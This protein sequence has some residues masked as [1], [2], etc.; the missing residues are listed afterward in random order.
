MHS[1]A[2]LRRDGGALVMTQ[3]ALL[4]VSRRPKSRRVRGAGMS[5]SGMEMGWETKRMAKR[6]RR[7]KVVK[8]PGELSLCG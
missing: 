6:K 1:Y 7:K 8:E 4:T 2:L 3:A 5:Q